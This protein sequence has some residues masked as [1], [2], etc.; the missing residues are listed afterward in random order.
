MKRTSSL[1]ARTLVGI[2]IAIIFFFLIFFDFED[3]ARK[4][5]C[6]ACQITNPNEYYL[7]FFIIYLVRFLIFIFVVCLISLSFT[8]L[9]FEND[10]IKIFTFL[11]SKNIEIDEIQK[12]AMFHVYRGAY[13]C[14]FY[15]K[16][17]MLT[18]FPI[19][20]FGIGFFEDLLIH[21]IQRNPRIFIDE[22]VLAKVDA[23]VKTWILEN[24]SKTT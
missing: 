10:K 3:F 2:F 6:L 5:T 17:R 22:S 21:I 15:S 9:S 23:K 13:S 1:Q 4:Y 19:H 18:G 14:G 24:S 20:S 12:I 8:R 16:Y 7:A 11:Y